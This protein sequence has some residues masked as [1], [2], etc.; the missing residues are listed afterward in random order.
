MSSSFYAGLL[1]WFLAA[2]ATLLSLKVS[3]TD[4][5]MI[6]ASASLILYGLPVV[7]VFGLVFGLLS[8]SKYSEFGAQLFFGSGIYVFGAFLLSCFIV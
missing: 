2:V 8:K 3:L 5:Q 7:M 1:S 6:R 4:P